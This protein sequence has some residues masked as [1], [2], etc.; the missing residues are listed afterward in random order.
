MKIKHGMTALLL[1]LGL[2]F[3][4]GFAAIDS[5][6]NP[7]DWVGYLPKVA[8]NFIQS[9][10]LLKLLSVYELVLAT[11]LLVG[12]QVRFA[13]MLSALTLAGIAVSNINLFIISFRDVGLVFAALA[14]AFLD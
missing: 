14:L 2:A 3:I 1:R 5:L 12:K 9:D 11:W 10:L 13:A 7:N 8:T 6:F 4:F